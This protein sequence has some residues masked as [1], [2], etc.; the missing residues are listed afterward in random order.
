[1]IKKD[2]QII[3]MLRQNGRLRLTQLARKTGMPVSTLFDKIK[4]AYAPFL[5]KCTFLINYDA[6]GYKSKAY[7]VFKIKERKEELLQYLRKHTNINTLF[8]VNNGWDILAEIVFPEMKEMEAFLEN[9]EQKYPIMQKEV[10]YI[11]EEITREA[12]LT[13]PE[14]LPKS[15]NTRAGETAI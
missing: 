11:L 8:R 2:W 6:A 9:L 14:L 12:F 3:A 7:V 5:R 4:R 15:L 13:N 10:H 1:M